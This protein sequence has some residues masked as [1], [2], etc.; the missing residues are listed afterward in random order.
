MDQKKDI[1]KKEERQTGKGM[2]ELLDEV[3]LSS[4][5]AKICD[6]YKGFLEAM[7][8]SDDALLKDAADKL[9]K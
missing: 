4:L 5:K 6:K 2:E 7:A 1:A 9:T 3:I 8:E